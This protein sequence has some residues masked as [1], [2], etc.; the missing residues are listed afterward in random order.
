M[1]PRVLRRFAINL[2]ILTVVVFSAWVVTQMF[3]NQ[4]PGDYHTRQGDQRLSEGKYAEALES[5]DKALREQ[6]NHR[7]ALMGRALVFIQTKKYEEAIA[8]MTHLI[9]FLQKNLTLDDKT[10]QG[11]LAAAYGNRGIVYDRMGKYELALAD[12]IRALRTDDATVSGPGLVDKI[13]YGVSK[14]STIRDRAIYLKEQLALPPEKR[15]L[16]VPELDK[17]QRMYKP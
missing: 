14:P 11:A 4:P 2:G 16:R 17:K 10:G 9:G 15:L 3:F 5:F 13:I 1:N 6:P 7:G 8:E 12:Y